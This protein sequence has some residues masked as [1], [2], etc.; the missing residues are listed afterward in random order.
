MEGRASIDY[1]CTRCHMRP[2]AFG[3]ARALS[4]YRRAQGAPAGLLESIILR[5]KYAREQSLGRA[6][7]E[8]LDEPLPLDLTEYN[9]V[10]PVPLHPT[11]L[12]WRRFN[13]S[14]L[15]AR[16]I[17]VE[18]HL[19][20]DL[21]TLVR[22]TFTQPQTSNDLAQRRRNVRNAFAV[23]GATAVR[24][25]A[26]LLVDDVITTGATADECAKTLLAAGARLVDVLAVARV[27]GQD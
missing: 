12:R 18:G 6:L 7:T 23:T 25:K 3:K 11:R 26:I 22:V 1:R 27:I 15:L 8:L 21:K 13:Q 24:G 2:P 14:A 4:V 16:A 10:V 19:A 20:L 17:A 5:H 9:L